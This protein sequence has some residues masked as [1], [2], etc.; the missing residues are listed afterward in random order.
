MFNLSYDFTEYRFFNNIFSEVAAMFQHTLDF[1]FID[2]F[3]IELYI[4]Q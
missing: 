4:F 2:K 3:S 1:R